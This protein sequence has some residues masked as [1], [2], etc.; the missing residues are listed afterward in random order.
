MIFSATLRLTGA[1]CSASHTCPIPPSPSFLI[2]RYGPTE[3]RSGAGTPT[4]SAAESRVGSGSPPELCGIELD[5]G[6]IRLSS[7]DDDAMAASLAP[8]QRSIAHVGAV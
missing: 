6:S 5:A 3:P 8:E 7:R 1:D 2:R 4:G